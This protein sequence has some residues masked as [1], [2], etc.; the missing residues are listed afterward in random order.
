MRSFD[1]N[2]GERVFCGGLSFAL[3]GFAFGEIPRASL[4]PFAIRD[5]ALK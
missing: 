2:Q 4:V 1:F 3:S 5:F